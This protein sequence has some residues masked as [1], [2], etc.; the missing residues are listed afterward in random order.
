VKVTVAGIVVGLNT[1]SVVRVRG[2]IVTV[3][4][5]DAVFAFP[6]VAVT[7]SV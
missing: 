6:S 4:E 1:K 5:A 3:L 7:D 2:L